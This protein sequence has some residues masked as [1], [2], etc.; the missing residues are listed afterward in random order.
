MLNRAVFLLGLCLSTDLLGGNPGFIENKNQWSCGIDFVA[1]IPGGHMVLRPGQFSYSFIDYEKIN[2]LH[3]QSHTA[4]NEINPNESYSEAI[5]GRTVNVNFLNSNPDA[6]PKASNRYKAYYNYFL[7]S[8]PT[9]WASKVYAYEEITYASLYNGIDL[10][11]FT[12]GHNIKYDF[13]VSPGADP[14]QI[15]IVYAGARSLLVKEGDLIVDGEFAEIMEKKPIAYQW[16]NG[17]QRFIAVDYALE[18]NQLSFY[19]PDGYDP[20]YELTIDPLII[21]STYSGFTADNWGSTATPGEN[22][23]LYSA[24]VTNETTFGGDFPA[25]NAES[26]AGPFQVNYGGAYDVAIF[27]Y[28]SAGQE[29]LYASFLGGSDSESPHSLIVNEADELIVLGTTSSFNYPTTSGVIDP[30]FNGGG[31]VTDHVVRYNNGSDIFVAKISKDGSQL[32]ASTFLGGS[33]LDGLNPSNSP[34]V[35]N[36]GDQLRGDIITDQQGDIF[37]STV[38]S[39]VD[40]PVQNSFNTTHGAGGTDAV[41]MKLSSDL[42][43]ILWGA[44]LGG[45]GMDAS[46][47]IKFDS[48]GNILVA[49]GTASANFP[50]TVGSYQQTLSGNVDGWIAKLKADGSGIIT[51]TY[52]GTSSFDQVYFLDLNSNDEVY[53]YGQTSGPFPVTPGVYNNPGSGQFLQKLSSDLTT[54]KFSTVFGSGIGI[55][56]I[57]PTAFLVN[58][59][60]NIYMTG[61]GG[62]VNQNTFHWNS[63]TLGMPVS[64]DAFQSTTSGSDFYFMVLTE[65]ATEF[66]YGTYMG[67]SLSRTHVDGGTSRFDKSGIVYHAVCSGCAAFNAQNQ[68]SSDFPTTAN[69]WSRNN[70][71][72]N[73][74]NAAFKFDLSSLRARIVTNSIKLDQ[75]GIKKICYPD[76]IVFQNRSTG[77][78]FYEWDFG[79]GTSEVKADTVAIVHQY[80]KDGNYLVKL[81]AVD[82]GTCVGEDFDY[83]NITVN[84]AKG[85]VGEDQTICFGAEVQLQAGGGSHYEWTRTTKDSLVSQAAQPFF[86]PKDTTRYFVSVTDVNNCVVNDTVNVNVVPRIELQFEFEKV[87]NCM[88]RASIKLLN[89]T[90]TDEEQFFDL[91]DDRLTTERQVTH[92]YEAD[93]NYRIRLVGKREFCVFEESVELPFFTIRVPNVITPGNTDANSAG[94]NDTFR[95]IYGD[96]EDSPTTTEAGIRVSLVVY[97]RWGKLAYQN[98]NY[99]DSWA[100]EGL[101]A[102]TYYYEAEI[103]NEPTCKGWIQIIR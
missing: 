54:L 72:Q 8:D 74:N 36:Y 15:K 64:G 20:C 70:N 4:F 93:G 61:W 60:N 91:G 97:N 53:V 65:D 27:K 78:Q 25:F 58:D 83:V 37:I 57:S 7:G 9:R 22:G 45:S 80:Q 95:I 94:K 46:H 50:A 24:G 76:K 85:W 3:D 28:D 44:F 62:V 102:G 88:D 86:S 81:R 21:F 66:L 73:C 6:V 56:N 48:Q 16:V 79:D 13:V 14:D 98:K 69:A 12:R 29:M 87:A 33:N 59:C 32:L 63:N 99:D 5:A 75:P 55:P 84:K 11:L 52:T 47:T 49:G 39:S 82:Q 101:E 90:A 35:V 18:N 31:G 51:A 17:T 103:E 77:G 42:T 92:T 19:F 23:K 40:F 41:V 2:G 100:G 67:G 34:L 96:S 1:S 38:T 71:S 68:S 30:T 10:K 89:N 43:Q 26:Q